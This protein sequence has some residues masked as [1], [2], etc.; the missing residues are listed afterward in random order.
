ML[1]NAIYSLAVPGTGSSTETPVHRYPTALK[2][3]TTSAPPNITTIFDAFLHRLQIEPDKRTLGRRPVLRTI[4]VQGRTRYQL[5]AYE[6]MTYREIHQWAREMGAGLKQLTAKRVLIYAPTSREWTLTMLSCYSQAL[7]VVT[8]YDTL[9][10]EGVLHAAC[11]T[12]AEVIFVKADQLPAVEHVVSKAKIAAVVYYR[13][14]WGMSDSAQRAIDAVR[15]RGIRVLSILEVVELGRHH[16]C[17]MQVARGDDTA[18]VMYTSGTTGPPKGVLI[19]HRGVLSICGAIHELVPDSIDYKDDRVL[20]YL[21]LSHVLAFFVET[22]CIYSGLHIGYGAPRTLTEDNLVDCLGDIREL[23]PAVMLGV[24]QVWNT[25]RASILRQ[26]EQRHPLVQRIFYGA[27]EL[28]TLLARWGAPT[29][30]LDQVVFR[31]TRAATGNLKIAIAGGAQISPLVHKFVSAAIC[32]MIHGYGLS[33]A[34]GLVSVQIPGDATLGNIGA[35][36]PSVEI[37]LVSV[38]E[39]G[40]HARDGRGEI[41]VRGPS[42]FKGYLNN[43][44]ATDEALSD[45]WLRTGDIGEWAEGGRLAI[46]DRQKNLVKLVTGE[47]VALEALESTYSNSCL[48]SNI[49]VVADARMAQPIALVNTA[50]AADPAAVFADLVRV[51]REAGLG[52]RQLLTCIRVDPELWT[53][54]NGMLTAASKLRRKDIAKRNDARLREMYAEVGILD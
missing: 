17:D 25:M 9:G 39:L 26:L 51:G 28:K 36:V 15:A 2:G 6:W 18:L 31:K 29:G 44:S 16:P 1:F 43:A 30:W 27:V 35:P 34:S 14:H 7:E 50:D 11:E 52:R 54:E 12:Q 42:V 4:E 46:I 22:Y 13:D 41:L 3:L 32:P 19:A 5:G 49:C 40:Y 45:G 53:P 33:E 37:K 38:P 47:Y 24:P 10:S 48:V 8:A 23:Q 20:S 21:P